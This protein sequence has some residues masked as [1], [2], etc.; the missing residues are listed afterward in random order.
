MAAT[1]TISTGSLD[2]FTFE[3]G[4]VLCDG[5]D[6]GMIYAKIRGDYWGIPGREGSYAIQMIVGAA[7]AN[8]PGETRALVCDLSE[9]I[10][11]GGDR[12][13]SWR[14]LLLRMTGG[15]VP[16]AVV[17]SPSNHDRIRSLIDYEDDELLV[18]VLVRSVDEATLSMC[19]RSG[20]P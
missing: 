8:N 18:D 1:T 5:A 16:F 10:Y 4:R 11:T 15:A 2:A 12:L 14:H 7:L 17:S 6:K 13:L 19:Q 3:I 9:L 20:G